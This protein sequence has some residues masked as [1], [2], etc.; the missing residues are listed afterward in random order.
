MFRSGTGPEH[1]HFPKFPGD[2][3]AAGLGTKF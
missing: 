2:V 3:A 1:L